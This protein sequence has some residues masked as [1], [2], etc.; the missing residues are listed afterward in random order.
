LE[1]K[2]V[3]DGGQLVLT[4]PFCSV[5][6]CLCSFFEV[7]RGALKKIEYD[8]LS[9]FGSMTNTKKK[10]RLAKWSILCQPKEQ[11]GLGIQ[12]IDMQNGCLN[13]AMKRVYSKSC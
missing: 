3:I 9:F 4:I 2:N 11:G 7:T 5:Y 13:F 1:R 12:N 6:Q 10:Y 8:T